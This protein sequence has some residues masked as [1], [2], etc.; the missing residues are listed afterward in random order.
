MIRGCKNLVTVPVLSTSKVTDFWMFVGSCDNLSN[1]SLNNILLM[2]KNMTLVSS[3]KTLKYAGLSS[4]QATTCT[5][6]SNWSAC[7]SL[8]WRTGY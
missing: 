7:Y 2:L 4:T 8:G 3:N 5:S 1:E 6:L